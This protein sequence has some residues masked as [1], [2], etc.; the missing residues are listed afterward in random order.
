ITKRGTL[1]ITIVNVYGKSLN[2]NIFVDMFNQITNTH[3]L[4]MKFLDVRKPDETEYTGTGV[5]PQAKKNK[6]KAAHVS[7]MATFIFKNRSEELKI[8]MN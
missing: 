5:K 3:E 2:I 1:F 8:P 4:R 6:Q 7:I